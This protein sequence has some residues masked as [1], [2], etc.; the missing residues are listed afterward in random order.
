LAHE[1]N[2]GVLSGLTQ[3]GAQKGVVLEGCKHAVIVAV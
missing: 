3:A 1:P 2:G